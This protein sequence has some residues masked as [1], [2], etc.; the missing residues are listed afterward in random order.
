M[1]VDGVQSMIVDDDFDLQ[2][3]IVDDD[4]DVLNAIVDAVECMDA[5][6]DEWL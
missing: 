1:D 6:D 3:A 5:F 2:N 4:F